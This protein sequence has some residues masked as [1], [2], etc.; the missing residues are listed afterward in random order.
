MQEQGNWTNNFGYGGTKY[1]HN[2]RPKI[3]LSPVEYDLGTFVNY[4]ESQIIDRIDL[5]LVG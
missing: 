3:G 2:L 1:V 5:A 4:D